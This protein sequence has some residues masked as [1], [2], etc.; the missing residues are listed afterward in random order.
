MKKIKRVFNRTLVI[1]MV[2]GMLL[3][4]SGFV[5]AAATDT[6][7]VDF[8]NILRPVNHSN[9]GY[10]LTPNYDIP[11][12]RM[13]LLGPLLNRETI[14]VQTYQGVGDLDGS[15]FNNEDSQLQ[16]CLEA[17]QR[18]KANGLEW[19][20]LLGLN[21]SWTAP[22]GVPGGG[23]PTNQ[24]WFKQYAKD[25]LQYFKDNGATPDFADLT[26]EYWTGLEPTFKGN[27]EAVR[28]VYPDYIPIVGPGAVGYAGI[29]DFY[30]PY[31][32]QNQM[33]LEGPCW[34]EYWEGST[35][36]SYNQTNKWKDTIVN[37]QNKYPE[38]NG[39]YVVWEENNSWSNATI[40][41]TRSMSNVVR[42]GITQNIK[43][44]IKSGNWNGMSDILTTTVRNSQQNGAVRT[45]IWWVYYMFSQLSGKYVGV[46][47]SSG[48]DF[49]A[50]ASMDTN[51]SKVIIAKSATAGTINVNLN[52][53]PYNGK[54]VRIDLYK[55]TGSE[56][57]GLTYQSSIT[58][59]STSNISFSIN[60]AA[61]NDSWLV[62]LK[63]VDSEPNFFHPLTP[64][65]G[66][67]ATVTPTLTWSAAQGA[68][69]YT[70]KVSVNKDMSNPVINQT[71]ITG[72][73]YKV[74]TPLTVDQKYYWKVTAE[75]SSGSR[76][77]SNDAV[78]SFIAVAN[79]SV[80]G[81]F[82]TYL[83][84][85]NAP[86][87][88]VTPRFLWSR[89][90][91]ATSYRLVV[92][93]NSDLSSPVINKTG[94]TTITGTNEFGPNTAS[95]FTPTT[96][97][98]SDTTY[99]WRVYAVNSNGERPM[100]GPIQYFTTRAAGNAPTSFSLT[101]PANSATD[102][103]NRAVLSW[104][105]SKNA[106][107]YKLE[108]SANADM[109]NPIILRD[110][111]IYNKYTVEPNLLNPNT[112]YY[113]RVSSFTKD[114]KYTTA[115]SSG[116][117]SFTIE[118]KPC[119]PL[120]YAH[121][122]DTNSVKLWFRSSK[123]ATSYNI[124]YGT[125]PGVYTETIKD[126]TSSPYTVT[127]LDSGTKYYFAVTAVNANGESSIWNERP[128]TTKGAAVITDPD[129]TLK[130]IL[131]EAENF[132]SQSGV[133]TETCTEG[134]KNVGYIE[135]GDYTVYSNVDFGI[136]ATEFQARVASYS[137]GGDI[138]IRLDSIDGTLIG[139]CP[140]TGT[141]GWQ[142]YVDTSCSISNV[143]G[144]HDVYLKFT[145]GSG[146]LFNLNWFKFIG[147]SAMSGDLNGDSTVDATDYAM[148]KMYLL[149]TITDLPAQNDLAAADLNG[150]GAIDAIDFAVFKKYLLGD[151]TKLPYTP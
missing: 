84:S 26:N 41:W 64:D 131:I 61:A 79:A 81:Q 96:A 66:E 44:C 119:S 23:A 123:G 69:S 147:K 89:A 151:I 40:D 102:V 101:A 92:S 49:T 109:S 27:W 107:F 99:Y 94:I 85:R 139:T 90:Y 46:S 86:M 21:P 105:P 97:L 19:Y 146:Y 3:Q 144:K 70:V 135:N 74:E 142:T 25:V 34:H 60:N 111:M 50:C 4:P 59:S 31:S 24:A 141:G 13:T 80:P 83:P 71:G 150:D 138:E 134:G 12:S 28:E 72:T 127:G 2:S 73:L 63:K 18:A 16:R 132:N 7:T 15:C 42:T 56:N 9:F 30:I 1:L 52:N 104:T 20:F 122:P 98:E 114:L 51:E 130:F 43:G 124:K 148:M 33:D 128:E 62:V 108:V 35:Y 95:T 115:S 58:P 143:T 129:P 118:N 121:Q 103:S 75:N 77:I 67:A 140:V 78:Y 112:K 37:L 87:Q 10:I 91:N 113:W 82:G 55:I 57:N 106:F 117:W 120:L 29:P 54:N 88:S 53:Q 125:A 22:K 14:P 47:T 116:V 65:D 68:E 145:G 5:E 6:V 48:D 136:G 11:D 133:E 149:G 100:N 45:P 93:K 137:S 17:Y 76:A 36:A 32:S 126:V 110:R 8:N 39:K 38:T